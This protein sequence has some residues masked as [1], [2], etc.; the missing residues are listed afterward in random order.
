MVRGGDAKGKWQVRAEFDYF[1][2]RSRVEG[3]VLDYEKDLF[4]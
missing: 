2:L 1:G 3:F 4:L